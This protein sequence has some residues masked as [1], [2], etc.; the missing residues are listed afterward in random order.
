MREKF[1]ELVLSILYQPL[2]G[3]AA[4]CQVSMAWEYSRYGERTPKALAASINSSSLCW[5]SPCAS[6]AGGPAL[7]LQYLPHSRVAAYAMK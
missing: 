6:P 1:V 3:G 2:H 7:T 5:P 4:G